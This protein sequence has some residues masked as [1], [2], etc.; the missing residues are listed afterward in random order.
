MKKVRQALNTL[1]ALSDLV[2]MQDNEI[3]RLRYIVARYHTKQGE[4]VSD[5]IINLPDTHDFDVRK[6][7]DSANCVIIDYKKL[8]V[9]SNY[10]RIQKIIN[11][12]NEKP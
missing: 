5:G 7:D 8:G 6:Y 11:S 3:K 12:L 10:M 4:G 1:E 2:Q 9:D